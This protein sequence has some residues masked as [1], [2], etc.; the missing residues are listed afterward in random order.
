M[1]TAIPILRSP[2]LM[3]PATRLLFMARPPAAQPFPFV[4]AAA[5][6]PALLCMLP[7]QVPAA[8]AACL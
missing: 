5:V 8:A 1:L 6:L 4:Q 3:L 7:F 2:R